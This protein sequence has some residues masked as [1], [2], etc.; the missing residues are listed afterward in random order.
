MDVNNA[1]RTLT[2]VLELLL[3]LVVLMAKLLPLD[4]L[5]K[6]TV[7]KVKIKIVIENIYRAHECSVILFNSQ[8][9]SGHPI[10]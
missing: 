4:L 10:L 6:L 9:H 1:K 8:I 3:V 2:V 5:L 7:K